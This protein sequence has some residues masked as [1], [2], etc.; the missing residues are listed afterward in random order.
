MIRKKMHAEYIDIKLLYLP[1]CLYVID[2]RNPID[3]LKPDQP[4]IRI[5]SRSLYDGIVAD[6]GSGLDDGGVGAGPWEG[7][8]ASRMAVGIVLA[9]GMMSPPS[10]STHSRMDSRTS[11]FPLSLGSS[12]SGI[13]YGIREDGTVQTT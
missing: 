9:D 1:S 5:V 7:W 12:V 10:T 8:L 11:A 4:A 2:R 13:N 3:K 6:G